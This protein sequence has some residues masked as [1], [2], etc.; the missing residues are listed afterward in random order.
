M[1]EVEKVIRDT[2]DALY[3]SLEC[4]DLYEVATILQPLFTDHSLVD[5]AQNVADVAVL[6]GCRFLIWEP[7]GNP[8]PSIERQ[9]DLHSED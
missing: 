3:S 8:T 5:L 6:G 9:K 1:P 2:L 7:H 4:V